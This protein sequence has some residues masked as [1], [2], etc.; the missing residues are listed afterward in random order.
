M[1]NIIKSITENIYKELKHYHSETVYQRAFSLELQQKP[2][3]HSLEVNLNIKYQ[4]LNVGF[5]RLDIVI[6][7]NNKLIILEFKAINNIT[8]KE[9]NQMHKYLTHSTTATSGYLINFGNKKNYQVI[10]FEKDNQNNI[11]HTVL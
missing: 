7:D 1:D 11:I 4:G 6:Y 2:I 5:C 8:E 9:T 3:L 10:K